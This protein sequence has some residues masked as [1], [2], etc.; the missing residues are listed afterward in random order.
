ML[1]RFKVRR[2]GDGPASFGVWDGAM[3]GWRGSDLTERQAHELPGELELR[4]D[5]HGPRPPDAVRRVQ[6]PRP[7][8]RVIWQAGG[9]LEVWVRHGGDWFGRVRDPAGALRWVRAADLRP[10][11]NPATDE[12][13]AAA[14]S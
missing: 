8:D 11:K 3:N 7:V 5:A 13:A 12:P 6:P 2:T 14:G 9:V 10:P 4:Y 1:V